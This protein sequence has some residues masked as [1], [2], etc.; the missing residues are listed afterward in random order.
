[1]YVS[2]NPYR[3]L[4]MNNVRYIKPESMFQHIDEVKQA[5]YVLFPEYWQVNTIFYGLKKKIFPS[6][7]TYH[8]GHTKVEMT[9]VL[10][11]TF[12]ENVPFTLIRANTT[13][14]REEILDT[15]SFP[16]IAKDIRN[17]MGRGV[18]FIRH[19]N[20][21][22]KYCETHEVLYVQEYLPIEKDM[23]I[24]YVGDQV[25]ESYW[26]VNEQHEYLTN[27]SQGGIILY[28]HVPLKAI[29][30]VEEI[31]RVLNINHAGFDVA[32]VDGHFYIFEFN[33]FFGNTGLRNPHY[34][35]YISDY[36][37]KEGS[38]LRPA[39]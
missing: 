35:Q 36:L 6:I 38:V 15:F 18:Y 25:I 23:R 29:Q 26:R 30:L 13:L 16:F 21:F 10:Q 27:V 14:N 32:E 12:S 34:H 33:V 19:E 39:N 5:E 8:L 4:G 2:F 20:D 17:S 7:S 22:S 11:A 31:A 28:D 3:T 9:R 37:M 24:V 1:M